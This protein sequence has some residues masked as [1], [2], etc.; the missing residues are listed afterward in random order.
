MKRVSLRAFK[1]PYAVIGSS[2]VCD[3]QVKGARPVQAMVERVDP[4]LYVLADLSEG[5]DTYVNGK[6][7]PRVAL[8]DGDVISV[9]HAQVV[10]ELK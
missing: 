8:Q 6:W 4:D 5:R 10:F 9:R 3:V 2:S 1:K 7:Y